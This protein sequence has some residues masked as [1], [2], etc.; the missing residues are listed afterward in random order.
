MT[1]LKGKSTL[2]GLFK[3]LP[4]IAQRL[5]SLGNRQYVCPGR[6]WSGEASLVRITVTSIEEDLG[7]VQLPQLP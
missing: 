6:M 7:G 4:A 1:P 3:S 2:Q 5:L